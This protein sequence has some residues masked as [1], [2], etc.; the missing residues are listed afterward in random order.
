M[1]S[2]DQPMATQSPPTSIDGVSENLLSF[3][4]EIDEK[5]SLH[6]QVAVLEFDRLELEHK[7]L[8]Y[9]IEADRIRDG[10]ETL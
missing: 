1:V 7:H 5:A 3:V 10:L 6:I 8:I 2:S 9:A 4:S